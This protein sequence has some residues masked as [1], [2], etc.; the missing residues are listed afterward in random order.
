MP[1]PSAAPGGHP[2]P[3]DCANKKGV[4]RFARK[5]Q[6][7]DGSNGPHGQRDDLRKTRPLE[8]SSRGGLRG[9]G[10]GSS[11][12]VFLNGYVER[13][14]QTNRPRSAVRRT[15]PGLRAVDH[16]TYRR[17]DDNHESS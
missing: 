15:V 10:D 7:G 8:P 6:T 13:L 12:L 16:R 9:Y 1:V 3:T 17:D 11:D 4:P 14:G 5:P 2:K